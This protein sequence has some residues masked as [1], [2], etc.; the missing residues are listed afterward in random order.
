MT[1]LGLLQAA[2][3]CGSTGRERAQEFG[4]WREFSLKATFGALSHVR[5]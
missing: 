3:I 4:G 1:L 5:R 2:S